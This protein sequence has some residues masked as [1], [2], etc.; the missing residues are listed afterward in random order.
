MSLLH[1]ALS[2]ALNQALAIDPETRTKLEAF[3][4]RTIIIDV[5]DYSVRTA[6]HFN[7]DR[8]NI[9]SADIAEGDLKISGRAIDLLSLAKDP[10]HLFSKNITIHGDVQFAK[11]LQDVFGGF[12]FDWE[13]QLAKVTGDTLAYPI[14]QGLRS[15]GQ[16]V[17]D[18]HHS[19]QLTLAEYLKEEARFLPDRSEINDYLNDID[20]LRADTDRLEARIKRL[21]AK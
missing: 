10:D 9:T 19:L 20:R 17:S 14:A 13:A 2:S 21:K 5:T 8:V 11:Q 7:H 1:T 16:W 18:S 15:L 12:D 3:N 4:G 6:C